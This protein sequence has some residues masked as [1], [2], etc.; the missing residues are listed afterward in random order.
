ESVHVDTSPV[1]VG[2][3]LYAGAGI[4]L[5][6]KTPEV[7]CLDAD[8]GK[9]LWRRPTDLPVWGS[10]QAAG[11]QVFFGLGNGRLGRRPEPP[12]K[13]AG[14]LLCVTAD[15]GDT[16]WR[17]LVSDAVMAR[18]AVD[19]E[20][21]YFGARDGFCYCLTRRGGKER[22]KKDL[23]SPVVTAPALVD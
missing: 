2:Q 1:V 3:R 5:T 13:P 6:Y 18:S 7:F 22:W 23:G 10:P 14:A 16:S 9:A 20:H 17:Y 12:E 8:S 15:S 19:R 4:S 21:V 11:R